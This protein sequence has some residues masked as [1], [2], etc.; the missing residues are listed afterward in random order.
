[1]NKH[2]KSVRDRFLTSLPAVH[3]L[4]N[5]IVHV[6][7]IIAVSSHITYQ[8]DPI[9]AMGAHLRHIQYTDCLSTASWGPVD[10]VARIC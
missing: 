9:N 1:M 2:T 3:V 10:G 6:P 8:C 4:R 5:M 7:L